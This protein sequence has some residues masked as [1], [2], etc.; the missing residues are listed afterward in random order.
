MS[1]KPEAAHAQPVRLADYRPT[2][3]LIDSVHLDISLNPIATRVISR[4]SLRPNPAGVAGA[5]LVLDGGDLKP[6]RALL[7]NEALDLAEVATPD[8]LTIANPPARP[9]T[10]EV[11]TLL[12]PSANTRLEGLYRSG[13]AYCTQCEAEGF[14]RIAYY[15]DRPDVM[16]VFTVRI[17]ADEREA[18]VLLSNGNPVESGETGN[19]RHYAIWHDPHP[20]P[21]YLF[22]LVG[23]DLGSIEDEF[24]TASGRNVKLAIHVEKGKEHRAHYAM[25]S[26]IHAMRWDEFVYG[27]EYDLDVF[28]I[29]AV[30]DFNMGAMENKGL[31]IFN[32][33]YILAI[34]ETATDH[35]YAGIE[36]VVAHEYFHNWTGN[37]ITCR[38][39]F[40]LCLKEGLT[41]YRDQEFTADQR[42][43]AVGR[44]ASVRTLR[45][46]QYPEDAGPLAHNVRPDTYSEINNFYT[47]TVYEKGAEIIRMLRCLIGHEAY[48]NGMALYFERF[49]GKAATVEDFLSCFAESAGRDLTQ[50]FQWYQQ[51][52]TPKLTARGS[53]DAEAKT[54]TLDLSQAT[55]PTPGQ[56][57]KK[58][59]LMPIRLGLI[60]RDGQEIALVQDDPLS[61]REATYGIFELAD[62]QRRIVFKDVP[63]KPVPSLVRRFSAPVILDVDLDE[64]DLLLMMAHDSD[65]FN[66]WQAAQTLATRLLIRST[67]LI[68]AGEL[69]DFNPPFAEALGAA[70][71]GGDSDPAFAAQMAALPSEGDIARDIG[72][73]VDPDA[74]FLARRAL[75]SDIGKLLGERLLTV[76]NRLASDA[77]YSPDA[78]SAGR[79]A[80]RNACLD[81][82]AAGN[83]ADGSEI[84]M[85]QFQAG[86]NMTDQMAAL[87]VLSAHAT[88]QRERALDSFFRSHA[89]EPLIVDKWFSLQAMIPEPETL[90]RVKRLMHNHAFSL[91]NP[92]R[93]RALIGAFA[94]GNPTG[95]NAAD[96]AGYRFVA[97][98]VLKLD[99]VNPQVAARLLSAFRSWRNLEAGRS[100][101]AREALELVAAHGALSPDL[102]DIVARSLA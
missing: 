61:A 35:D 38:D 16:S 44:I 95:F 30:P 49:D 2:D 51:A 46:A 23:G 37:R 56:P 97:E 75:R 69:P 39:W 91:T 58:P 36:T 4:L 99:E 14:R 8:R 68:R 62:A 73:D 43:R 6:Y 71:E 33:K 53:Y 1:A 29:V 100:G 3:Y 21:S 17:E 96:G 20:K 86:A 74:I 64:D 41:V 85:R 45:A 82:Y 13:S 67:Q 79:R 42:S 15:L 84:A 83:A 12:D 54:Y 72:S 32:D 57:E 24:T 19:G 22:A 52:G 81:L 101:L 59:L 102:R 9:F 25:E 88:Q 78:A 89:D 27:R 10:L 28:N 94:T 65:P 80:L 48:H 18:P 60:G 47:A 50:F 34:Q 98:T 11:E 7:D 63:S 77:P 31:N 92:N 87:A 70:I 90:A 66:R 5:P 40:Q 93:V 76:Y 55:P 26:L